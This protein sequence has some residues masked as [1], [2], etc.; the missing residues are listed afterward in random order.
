MLGSPA[1][2]KTNVAQ[3]ASAKFSTVNTLRPMFRAI[4]NLGM[5]LRLKSC[6]LNSLDFY[7]FYFFLPRNRKVAHRARH[8]TAH[9]VGAQTFQLVGQDVT[10]AKE[11]RIPVLLR[12]AISSPILPPPV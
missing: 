12:L 10:R 6:A 5:P 9:K 3:T 11:P 7:F 8:K 4:Y 1:A 2:L